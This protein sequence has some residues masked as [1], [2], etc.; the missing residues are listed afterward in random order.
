MRGAQ[1][2]RLAT[3]LVLLVLS[4]YFLLPTI[5]LSAMSESQKID[6]PDV[7]DELTGK[8]I[9]LGLDLRGGIHLLMEPDMVAMLGVTA[10]KKD[11][12]FETAL[13]VTQKI[14]QNASPDAT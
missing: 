8:T 13:K 3:T 10:V 5:R 12:G 11:A 1:I 6:R 2:W 7:V 14:A 4:V 9:K